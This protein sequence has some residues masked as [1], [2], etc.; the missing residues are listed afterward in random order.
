MRRLLAVAGALSVLCATGAAAQKSGGTLRMTH[1]EDPGDISIHESGTFSVVVP[2]MGVFNNLVMFDPQKK[3]NS[4]DTIVPDLATAWKWNDDGTKLTLTLR[5]G[6]TWHDGKPFT[7]KDVQ[8]TWDLLADRGKE[9]FRLNTRKGWYVNVESVTPNGDYEATFNLKRPQPALLSLLASGFTPVYPCHVSPAQM[10]QHPIGTGPFK[11]VEYVKNQHIKFVRNPNYWKTGRPYLDAVEYTIIPSR[12]TAILA[13]V[14]G[15]YDMFF[16]YELTVPLL[17]DV[18]QQFPQA[19]CEITPQNVAANILMNPVPPFDN[20]EVRRAVANALDRKAF[21]DIMTQGKGAI[22]AAMLPGPEGRWGL[23]P[24]VLKDLPGYSDDVAGRREKARAAMQAAGFGPDKRLKVKLAS[25]NLPTYRDA[26]VI[27]S[28]QLKEI[29]IDAELE[30]VETANWLAKLVRRDY[31]MALSQVGNGVDDP[32]QNYPENYAC[33]S[34]T[35]MGYCDK[36]IDALIE[37]QSRES[38]QEKRKLIAWE[39]DKKLTRD[40]VRPMLYY[41]PGVSCWRPEVK[42]LNIQ[43]NS[44]YNNWRMEEVWLDK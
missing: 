29:Y 1:R 31:Q 23:P 15:R 38:D 42:G 16:P 4:L 41:L 44:I 9:R 22:G 34:R 10:R 5:Q 18:K 19:V 30:M 27:L 7:A 6:V 2:F 14:S 17:A 35:Y 13:F 33:G 24:E 11:F 12:S 43:V 40:A 21:V 26:A 39:I 28:S 25:R 3:Q 8:C 37:K 36:D 32:D 20:I